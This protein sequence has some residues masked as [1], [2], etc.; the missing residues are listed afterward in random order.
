MLPDSCSCGSWSV[1]ACGTGGCSSSQKPWTR[2]CNPSACDSESICQFD[3]SCETEEEPESTGAQSCTWSNYEFCYESSFGDCDVKLAMN[4]YENINTIRWGA[5]NDSW[6]PYVIDEYTIQWVDADAEQVYYDINDPNGGDCYYGGCDGEQLSD[7]GTK[8]T[9]NTPG[10]AHH[11]EVLGYDDTPSNACWVWFHE[12]YP[13]YGA[14]NNVFVLDCFN[15]SD[16]SGSEYCAKVGSWNN[17]SCA[18]KKVDGQSCISG[19]QCLSNYCDNDGV[20]LTDNNWC[21]TPFNNSFDGQETSYC[22][23]STNNGSQSCDERQVGADLNFCSGLPYLEEECSTTCEETDV[24]TVFECNDTNCSCGEPLCDGLTA[25]V[26]VTTCSS[27]ET[28]FADAC[29]A[30]AS[31]QDR[32]ESV[33]RSSSFASGCTAD[34]ICNG[35]VA[36]TGDCTLSCTFN[37]PPQYSNLT[38]S[39]S[40]PALNLSGTYMFNITWTDDTAI[41]SVILEFDGTNYTDVSQNGDV[42]GKTFSDLTTGIHSY[43]WFA[44][45]TAGNSNVTLIQTYTINE[46]NSEFEI[47]NTTGSLKVFFGDLGHLVLKGTLQQNSDYQLSDIDLF[48]IKNNGEDVLVVSSNGSI[49]ID[50]TLHEDQETLSSSESSNDFRI[51]N[52][53]EL[54]A[55]VNEFGHV[56]LKGTLI[57]NG[58][59]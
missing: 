17:W 32:N 6:D 4:L 20:G 36:G 40:D 53:G 3:A 49:F 13:N 35:I 7:A 28:Y 37:F 5:V 26:N 31:G 34:D 15:N 9:V 48:V 8:V 2:T 29:T 22:E 54:V 55:Y 12:F 25:G 46:S 51:K 1:G 10:N 33:C 50:G 52:N 44:N 41:D 38:E 42:Y 11:E 27:G 21:F 43:Y 39:P 23:Y 47:Y 24:T 19:D 57:E 56:F 16:C 18:S 14:G 45:D 59:S 30:A 58:I